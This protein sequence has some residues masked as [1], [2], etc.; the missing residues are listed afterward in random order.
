MVKDGRGQ[1][2]YESCPVTCGAWLC[3]AMLCCTDITPGPDG[4]YYRW[5]AKVRLLA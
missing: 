4:R 3:F 1:A 5:C 2:V